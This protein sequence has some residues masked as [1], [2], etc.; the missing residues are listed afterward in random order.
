MEIPSLSP[1][2]FE[3]IKQYVEYFTTTNL[4]ALESGWRR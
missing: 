3:K 4:Y 2:F 1:E